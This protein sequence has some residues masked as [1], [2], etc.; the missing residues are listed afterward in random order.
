[1][2]CVGVVDGRGGSAL[3]RRQPA[4]AFIPFVARDHLQETYEAARAGRLAPPA[5]LLSLEQ[6]RPARSHGGAPSAVE[7]AA[8]R[9]LA[10]LTV[11]VPPCGE[12]PSAARGDRPS[13]DEYI[14]RLLRAGRSS[15]PPPLQMPIEV[16]RNSIEPAA[17]EPA[18]PLAAQPEAAQEP[19]RQRWRRGRAPRARART[20]RCNWNARRRSR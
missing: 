18:V 19:R 16:P 13:L 15:A 2:A 3:R 17:N 10:S 6:I 4:F 20:S 12:D 14:L 1:M 9:P 8:G 5:S 11:A 7:R